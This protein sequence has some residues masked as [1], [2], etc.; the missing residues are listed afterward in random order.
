MQIQIKVA[1]IYMSEQFGS[2][3]KYKYTQ[4]KLKEKKCVNT[5]LD[6]LDRKCQY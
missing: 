4:K 5:S 3:K 1:K 6:S 2:A